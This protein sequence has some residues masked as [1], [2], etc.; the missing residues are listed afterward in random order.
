MSW[1]GSAL[2]ALASSIWKLVSAW[3]NVDRIRIPHSR[4]ADFGEQKLDD[5]NCE[6]ESARTRRA[7]SK[8]QTTDR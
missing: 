7:M 6:V 8:V 3:W 1:Q 4:R 5:Q 2:K